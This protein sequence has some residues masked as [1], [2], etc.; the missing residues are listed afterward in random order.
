MSIFPFTRLKNRRAR[1]T[2]ED[3]GGRTQRS[4]A[5][6]RASDTAEEPK[7]S[8]RRYDINSAA[9]RAA[10]YLPD[11]EC[12]RRFADQFRRIK[13]PL[14]DK[15][16]SAE[17]STGNRRIVVVTSA[18]PGDG[19]TFTSI[20]LALSLAKERDMSVLLIDA[21]VAKRSTSRILGLDS[22]PGLLDLLGENNRS[23]SSVV[24]STSTRGLS[25]LPVGFNAPNP[26]ELMSSGRMRDIMTKLCSKDPHRILLIDSPPLLLTN[27]G[28]DLLKIAG[29]IVLVVR[30]G[31]TPRHA[32]QA[33]VEQIDNDKAGGIVLNEA[34]GS[35]TGGYYGYGY[36]GTD[37]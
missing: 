18:L 1:A 20:N 6:N 37:G 36:Y 32:V 10:G 34:P 5:K 13:R 2:V 11:A 21:D 25:I 33:A 23:V 8:T 27:E 31:H 9:L 30:A 12:E 24:L 28:P 17:A 19:K 3:D 15:A 26:T 7:G 22:Q 14:I 35:S 29:Q 4:R 16:M